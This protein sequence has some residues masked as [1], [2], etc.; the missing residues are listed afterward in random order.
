MKRKLQTVI[1]KEN[2]NLLYTF[3]IMLL[4]A[5][6]ICSNFFSIHFS[7]DT[8]CIIAG[9][10]YDKYIKHFLSIGRILGAAQIFITKTFNIPFD[11]MI[12]SS[13]IFGTLFLTLSWFML[14]SHTIKM[15]DVR[16]KTKK[17]VLI[18][19]ISFSIVFN[20]CTVETLVFAESA[21]LCFS[22]FCSILAACVYTSDYKY[23]NIYT[24]ILLFLTVIAYQTSTALFLIVALVF[25]A[26]K[27][28]NDKVEILKKSMYAGLIY[29]ISMFFG[30]LITKFMGSYLDFV[31]RETA[32]LTINEMLQTLFKYLDFIVLKNF[33]IKTI[34]YNFPIII[35]LI[36][37]FIILMIKNKQYFHILEYFILIILGCILPIIPLMVIPTGS[38]YMEPRMA[39]IFGSLAGILL[40]YLI[41]VMNA[42]EKKKIGIVIN[43]IAIVL[44][45]I[46][47]S[48]FIR[49][50]SENLAT[51]YIDKNIAKSIIYNIEK[52]E[53]E[54]NIKIKKIVFGYDASPTY[55]YDGQ[56]MLRSINGRGLATNFTVVP[57]IQYYSGKKYEMNISQEKINEK[58]SKKNWD[59]FSEDQLIF[60]KDT[61]YFCIY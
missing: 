58:F 38:Q 24:A 32:L 46:N 48:N 2:I 14:Y 30:L 51:G 45:V 60:E 40:L 16:K 17:A 56:I 23:K 28:K 25:T 10:G 4:F 20:F 27:N 12:I 36:I 3:L 41:T 19:G 50:S 59:V 57:L 54:N 1:K 37:I 33:Y 49:S 47:S 5:I 35:F 61:L 6:I 8:Y 7:Q 53:K 13:S 11:L 55:Y 52:Y 29:G 21:V 31:E 43:I 22:I 42:Y 9:Y 15:I 39:M 26:I 44:F 18:A 34:W